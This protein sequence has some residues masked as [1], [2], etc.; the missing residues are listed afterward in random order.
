MAD[1]R[2]TT[3]DTAQGVSGCCGQRRGY[4][5]GI[6]AAE[7]A[8][9][10]NYDAIGNASHYD[11]EIECIDALEQLARNGADFRVLT[12][13]K[14][15]WRLGHKGNQKLDIIKAIWYLQRR[16]AELEAA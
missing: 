12:A 11:G 9:E 4:A 1:A 7:A 16:L 10:G 8:T 15:L 3:D 14:Y 2:T 5:P 13:M 6:C